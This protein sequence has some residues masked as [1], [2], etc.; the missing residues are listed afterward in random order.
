LK[1]LGHGGERGVKRI[2]PEPLIFQ[3]RRTKGKMAI[4]KLTL[5]RTFL[6]LSHGIIKKTTI[7]YSTVFWILGSA[8][9]LVTITK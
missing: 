9:D 6:E 2:G 4:Q 5:K 1:T 8:A 7:R 3:G